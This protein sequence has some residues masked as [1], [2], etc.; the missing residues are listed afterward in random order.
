[1]KIYTQAQ[2]GSR[3]IKRL[4]KKLSTEEYLWFGLASA[5]GEVS[6]LTDLA[7]PF[8]PIKRVKKTYSEISM[9]EDDALRREKLEDQ[10]MLLGDALDDRFKR[11]VPEKVRS[12]LWH[13]PD[14]DKVDNS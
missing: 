10:M 8:G 11:M 5:T 7:Y 1:M 2:T 12:K 3:L 9:I 6:T 14:Q 4:A 13:P